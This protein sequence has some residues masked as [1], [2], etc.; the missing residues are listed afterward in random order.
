[1]SYKI[2]K[3]WD[4]IRAIEYVL[5]RRKFATSN[6]ELTFFV[7]K[8]LK[9]FDADFVVSPKRVKKIALRI[10]EVK[11][12]TKT[13]R[14][15]KRKKLT[16]CPVCKTKIKWIFRKNLKGQRTH[17]GYRCSKC[18]FKTDKNSLTPMKYTFVW[19]SRY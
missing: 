2:P 4:I 10:P 1:M 14:T 11:I 7:T 16:K 13:R 15:K 18:G 3:D 12:T 17:T 8:R 6:E 9:N 5:K 19:K